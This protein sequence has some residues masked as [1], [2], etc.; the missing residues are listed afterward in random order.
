MNCCKERNGVLMDRLTILLHHLYL[1]HYWSGYW[2]V[3]IAEF[4]YIW[5]YRNDS[6]VTH[7]S[8]DVFYPLPFFQN[9]KTNI[10]KF[11]HNIEMSRYLMLK[12]L[13]LKLVFL[14]QIFDLVF[15]F[16]I[17]TESMVECFLRKLKFELF[18]TRWCY[19]RWA[20]IE[21]ARQISFNCQSVEY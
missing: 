18:R 9:R 13:T 14:F 21:W 2:F 7:I 16:N 12:S 1:Q 11:Y 20:S 5:H 8:I 10:Y 15:W 17:A 3:R 6:L 4:S 19:Q